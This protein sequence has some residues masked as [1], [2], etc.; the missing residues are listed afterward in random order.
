MAVISIKHIMTCLCMLTISFLMAQNLV[1]NPSFEDYLNCPQ[2]LGKFHDNVIS[3]SCP[4]AGT[5]DYF[6]A[7]SK[8]MGTPENFKGR[9]PADFGQGYVGLY[10]YAPDDYREYLQVELQEPLVK[11]INYQVSFYVSL[12]D[13]SDS[14]IK[15]FG[16]LF[17]KDQLDI[18]TQ[19]NLSKRHWYQQKG[20]QYNYMEI[21][22]TNFYADTQ[23]WILVQT[24]FLAKGTERYLTLGNFKP[25]ARTRMFQTKR[26]VKQGSYYYIDMVS[27]TMDDPPSKK[28]ELVAIAD[29][30]ETKNIEL[31]KSY[32]FKNV[33]FEF[34]KSLLLESS[35]KE[36]GK[37][38]NHLKS[39]AMLHIA[40]NGHTDNVG[41]DGYNQ[42]LSRQRAEAVADYL[43]RLGIHK[44]RIRWQGHGDKNPITENKTEA[45]RQL[46]RRVEF[47]I[48][49]TPPTGEPLK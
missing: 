30:K 35:K 8:V 41:T 45:G 48:S 23:D 18:D 9:Q 47:T 40:I 29:G 6:N 19:K 15:E 14:A 4:S 2:R 13:R 25:N 33:L 7:C 26:N 36:L 37:V 43:Q 39:N 42:K 27:V 34:D 1:Q 3:W 11:G 46:N 44:D 10:V 20:N 16:V 38:Y 5:T 17:S 24:Q 12:A 21:G 32:I 49:K 22:Y 31:D 28:T